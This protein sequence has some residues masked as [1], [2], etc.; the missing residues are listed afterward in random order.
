MPLLT[1]EPVQEDLNVFLHKLIFL[2]HSCFWST[3]QKGAHSATMTW[4]LRLRA[5]SLRK[6]STVRERPIVMMTSLEWM[7]SKACMEMLS[8]VPSEKD[9][10]FFF[11]IKKKTK[12]FIFKS[13]KSRRWVFKISPSSVSN[14]LMASMT[15]ALRGAKCCL[16]FSSLSPPVVS[17]LWR[18]SCWSA[19]S[20]LPRDLEKNRPNNLINRGVHPSHVSFFPFSLLFLF[21]VFF[22]VFSSS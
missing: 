21:C 19:S 9:K 12:T 11:L 3:W 2:C 14:S 6:A 7:C 20:L 15:L 4:N 13:W 16:K 17:S 10:W 18:D 1:G 8:V 5:A 22:S